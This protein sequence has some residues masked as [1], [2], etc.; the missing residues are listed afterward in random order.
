MKKTD[1]KNPGC[2]LTHR[3][4]PPHRVFLDL[5]NGLSLLRSYF[6]RILPLTTPRLSGK[7]IDLGGKHSN[8]FYHKLLLNRDAEI[9]C[10]DLH[11]APGV[12]AVDVEKKL[13]FAD[14]SFDNILAFWLFEHVYDFSVI[15][16]EAIR[17]LKPGGKAIVSVPFQHQYH[18]DSSPSGSYDDYWRFSHTALLKWW[19]SAG[20]KCECVY[21]LGEGMICSHLVRSI[22]FLTP[23]LLG[24]RKLFSA[25]GY[26]FGTT[27]ERLASIRP[28]KEPGWSQKIMADGYLAVFVKPE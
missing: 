28:G 3:F 6:H 13:P 27:L 20:F 7:I 8:N 9:I 12:I 5:L 14:A 10:T 25:I 19:E 2:C 11:A 4:L 21:A 15:A 16:G 24:I 23:P 17:V 1:S 18:G 26:L 22:Q